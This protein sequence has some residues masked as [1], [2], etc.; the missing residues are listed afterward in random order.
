M[1][2][3]P[4]FLALILLVV[5]HIYTFCYP[6]LWAFYFCLRLHNLSSSSLPHLNVVFVVAFIIIEKWFSLRFGTRFVCVETEHFFFSRK[7]KALPRGCAENERIGK[8][9]FFLCWTEHWQ[10]EVFR[11]CLKNN[12]HLIINREKRR[13]KKSSRACEKVKKNQSKIKVRNK[14]KRTSNWSLERWARWRHSRTWMWI[15]W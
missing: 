10:E 5:L 7:L 15:S 8:E 14:K 1:W 11:A 9:E 13:K 2:M 4:Y 12:F 6:S 3:L